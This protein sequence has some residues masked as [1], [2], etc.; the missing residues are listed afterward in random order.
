MD[1]TE[2]ARVR[3]LTHYLN[4]VLPALEQF[5][6]SMLRMSPDRK[7]RTTRQFV[8]RDNTP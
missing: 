7:P 1:S 6:S 3:T 2:K 4:A 8:I 5:N